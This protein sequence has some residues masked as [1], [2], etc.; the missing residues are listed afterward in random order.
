MADEIKYEYKTVQTV[1]GTDGLVISKMQKDGWELV[2][3][4]QGKLRSTLNFR[5]PKKPQPWLLIG[6]AAAVPVILAIVIGVASALS[7]GGE[8]K[9]RADKP[10]VAAGEKPSAAPTPSA[11]KSAAT[12]V[13]TPQNDPK[14]AALLKAD[15]CDDANLDF[16]TRHKGQTI[17][18]NG[19]IVNMTPHGDYD[20]R[21]DFLLG[22]GDKGPNTTV[23]PAFK[24]ENVNTS[25]LRLTGKNIPATV[26]TGDKFHFVAKVGEFNADQCLFFLEPIST[27]TR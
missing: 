8:K 7:H 13:I 3:Q 25:D 23:G 11:T 16:A 12:K 26:G 17:A 2:E 5:R 27:E 20:T 4:A 21:Y 19:S 18:F 24:Y 10:A 6:V 14:F 1:R 15:S 22:P 9:D